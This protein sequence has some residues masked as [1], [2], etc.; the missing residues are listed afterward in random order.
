MP[1]KS[2]SIAAVILALFACII[3]PSSPLR[4]DGMQNNEPVI[5]DIDIKAREFQPSPAKLPL[6]REVRLVFRNQ[7]AELHAFVPQKFL[8]GIPLH[9]EGNGAPQFGDHGLVRV[10]IPSGGMAELR[11]RPLRT[12]VY[13]YRCYLPG[14]QMVG[15]FLIE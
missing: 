10:L 8:E 6:D 4:A 1:E 13:E 5:I 15:R 11:F 14:H 7:D 3:T 2:E 9:L 12:G